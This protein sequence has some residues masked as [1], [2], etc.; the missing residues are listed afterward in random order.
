MKFRILFLLSISL[1][2]AAAFFNA[3]SNNPTSP[4]GN[5]P[6]Y[7]PT[8]TLVPCG[9]PGNTCTLTATPSVTDTGTPTGT[10]TPSGTPTVTGT[11][12]E[13]GSPTSTKTATDTRTESP[14]PSITSSPT[15]TGTST[16]TPTVTVTPTIT[17]T[18]AVTPTGTSTPTHTVVC[19]NTPTPTNTPSSPTY[20]LTGTLTY[21]PGGVNST[22]NIGIDIFNN[23][24]TFTSATLVG[25]AHSATNGFTYKYPVRHRGLITS[26][27]CMTPSGT[28]TSMAR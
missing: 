3:C 21:S 1:A 26:A 17:N 13:T 15:E 4:G 7:T 14:T 22:N 12:T 10:F 11:P 20:Y 16:S 19:A 6:T 27:C 24:S 5:S 18:F 23:A 2:T 8:P 28:T 25:Q 9:Y